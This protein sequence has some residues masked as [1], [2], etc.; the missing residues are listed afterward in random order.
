MKKITKLLFTSLFAI[1]LAGCGTIPNVENLTIKQTV[2][3]SVKLNIKDEQEKEVLELFYNK[4]KKNVKKASTSMIT[5]LSKSFSINYKVKDDN[6]TIIIFEDNF[7]LLTKQG[8]ESKAI[9]FDDGVYASI[10][11]Y[12][13]NSPDKETNKISMEDFKNKI[14]E[15]DKESFFNTIK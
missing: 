13:D 7:G 9:K 15:L 1:T 8:D 2:K 3:P 6:F 10:K 5:G 12:F 4:Y 11:E 14:D